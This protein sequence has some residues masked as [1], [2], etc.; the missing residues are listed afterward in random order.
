[1]SGRVGL[2]RRTMAGCCL[3]SQQ[4][5]RCT[6]RITSDC[7]LLHSSDTYLYAPAQRT[8]RQ[9]ERERDD[10]KRFA[11]TERL[12]NICETEEEELTHGGCGCVRRWRWRGG[13]WSARREPGFGWEVHLYSRDGSLVTVGWARVLERWAEDGWR[14]GPSELGLPA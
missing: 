9:R 8:G 10:A 11:C 2:V 1:M 4:R 13:R 14:S 5:T 3:Y 12:E 6:K 7:F